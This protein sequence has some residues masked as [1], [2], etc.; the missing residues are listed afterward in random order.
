MHSDM[1][2]AMSAE[3]GPILQ[4]LRGM[5]RR[6]R[7]L[8]FCAALL[9]L[10]TVA[11][12]TWGSALALAA[13]GVDRFTARGVVVALGAVLLLG[14]VA[15]GAH[16][17]HRAGGLVR[18][19]GLVEAERPA[20][21]G[22]LFVLLDRVDG[23]QPHDS[24]ALLTL[25][26]KRAAAALEG[27]VPSMVHPLKTLR[28][29]GGVAG[30]FAFA[31]LVLAV[32]G[33]MGPVETLRWLGGEASTVLEAPSEDPTVP[34]E[35][36]LLGDIVLRYEY[37][38][39]TGLEPFEVENTGGTIHAPPGTRVVVRARTAERYDGAS[40]QIGEADPVLAE[41]E[42][43]RELRAELVVQEESSYRFLLQRGAAR[44]MSPDFQIRVEPD[45]APIV[46]VLTPSD[47][48]EVAMDDLIVAEWHAR[49][50]Y[51]L[52]TVQVTA[53]GRGHTLEPEFSEL[54]TE[55]TGGLG[56]TPRD[57]GLSPGDELALFIVAWD[58]DPIS[59]IKEGRSRPIRI[60]V[61][62]DDAERLRFIRFRRELRD[63][64]VDVL[65]DFVTDPEPI[66]SN[67]DE[68][69]VWGMDSSRRFDPLDDLVDEYWDGFDVRSLEGRIIGEVRRVGG[70]LVRFAMDLGQPGSD[71]PLDDRDVE[72]LEEM[73]EDFVAILE[74]YI[75][76]L[77]RV[78]QYQALGELEKQISELESD[79]LT[80]ELMLGNAPPEE[81]VERFQGM[82]ERVNRFQEAAAD[83]DNG[84]LKALGEQWGGD[85]LRLSARIQEHLAAG[86][87]ESAQTKA[88]WYVEET[89]RL[90]AQLESMQSEMQEASE[91]EAEQIQKLIE[92]IKRLE[93]EER[94]L[95]EKTVEAREK[96]GV[97]DSALIAGWEEA[98]RLAAVVV[99]RSQVAS[100]ALEEDADAWPREKRAGTEA[101]ELAQRA[102]F[103]VRARDL[104]SAR[105]DALRSRLQQMSA[106]KELRYTDQ[107][108]AAR[109]GDGHNA[110]RIVELDAALVA[111]VDL[112]ELLDTLATASNQSTPALRGAIE[113]FSRTQDALESSTKAIQPEAAEL[114]AK[115]PMGA[116][117]LEESL[118]AAVREMQ[119]AE[120]SLARSWVVEAEGA[121]E[122]AADRLRQAL[123]ALEQA[124]AAASQM[125]EAMEGAG[126]SDEG[127]EGGEGA[128]PGENHDPYLDL[129]SEE[130]TDDEYREALMEGMQSEVPEEY[131]ALKRRYYE[132]LV[133]H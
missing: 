15:V 65:A 30:A 98:E 40:L 107:R 7:A 99:A 3:F 35:L 127:D 94:A 73:D 124:A 113:G 18:Q 116:P 97:K 88:V 89:A 22:R 96:H 77:D 14:V 24:E 68:L 21:R 112:E 9:G 69:V 54:A 36:A 32:V 126:G 13:G 53:R 100:V 117:G 81:I 67:E 16:L 33:P 38:A 75:L 70:G 79:A 56:K 37:P 59:G 104:T 92:E 102:Q 106:S 39:Y 111:A 17:W 129:P 28:A 58:N 4:I 47:R 76:M 131:E 123:E 5:V 19:A 93:K 118:D 63:A 101:F 85:L 87:L 80:A 86:E 44:A 90:R 27:L 130:M 122:A 103:A 125:G 8:A 83:F 12:V 50:D 105:G 62:G 110:S 120:S 132:E 115:L 46:D 91:E 2:R 66:A 84:R 48:M 23:L 26:A 6:E 55:W 1:R 114:A 121:E 71:A 64:L 52:S 82:D 109:G 95:L 60:I 133:R 43:G 41:L 57:L 49:D 45:T 10:F 34:V 51:G 61:L 31:W 25:A 29:P 20:L 11:L 42:V 72:V 128:E 119:R 78:V 74:S 108:R